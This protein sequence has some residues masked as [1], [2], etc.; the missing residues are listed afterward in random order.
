MITYDSLPKYCL[1]KFRDIEF[2][3]AVAKNDEALNL[4]DGVDSSDRKKIREAFKDV[5]VEAVKNENVAPN[6]LILSQAYSFFHNYELVDELDES[7]KT[8]IKDILEKLS[9]LEII[10][11]LIHECNGFNVS[12]IKAMIFRLCEPYRQAIVKFNNLF[13]NVYKKEYNTD[14]GTGLS[15]DIPQVQL[16]SKKDESPKTDNQPTDNQV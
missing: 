15:L 16:I 8:K 7:V 4:I 14:F 10:S 2:P 6:V 1:L 3:K 13:G 12:Y 11:E 5:K 9:D